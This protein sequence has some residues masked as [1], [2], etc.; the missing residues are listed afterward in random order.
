MR[1]GKCGVLLVVALVAGLAGSGAMAG[2]EKR[3]R[4]P[5]QSAPPVT[6]PPRPLPAVV[7]AAVPDAAPDAAVDA[8]LAFAPGDVV[9]RGT[10]A[11]V[12]R[13]ASG[14]FRFCFETALK[15]QPGL[16][17]KVML[18]FT[19]EPDGSVQTAVATGLT[20]EVEQ[21]MV[22][23]ARKLRFPPGSASTKVRFPFIFK[24]AP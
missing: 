8:G 16:A 15:Q 2:C 9:D 3:A 23:R 11:K 1:V 20:P 7:D 10:I 4:Q 14:G 19:I 6:A 17:G 18:E 13:S 12:V 5:R 22:E 21:C 24:V